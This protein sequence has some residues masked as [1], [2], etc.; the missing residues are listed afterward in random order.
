MLSNGACSFRIGQHTV[1]I[2]QASFGHEVVEVEV[3]S[4]SEAA[5]I[6]AAGE[7]VVALAQSLGVSNEGESGRLVK[8]PG[9]QPS[10]IVLSFKTTLPVWMKN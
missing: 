4:G 10:M 2:D 6:A 3:I 5:E 9:A 8:V 1:D 7:S